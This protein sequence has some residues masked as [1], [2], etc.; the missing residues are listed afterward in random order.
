MFR[1]PGDYQV[2]WGLRGVVFWS[3]LYIQAQKL[4]ADLGQLGENDNEE[5]LRGGVRVE[6][7]I[8]RGVGYN[9]IPYRDSYTGSISIIDIKWVQ[10]IVGRGSLQSEI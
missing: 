5:M 9:Y 3:N 1:L 2:A 6:G 8:D 7:E 4:S 10:E